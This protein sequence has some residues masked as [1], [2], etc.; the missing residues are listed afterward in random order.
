MLE[1]AMKK[2]GVTEPT[3]SV[4]I[5]TLNS[6][7]TLKVCLESIVSQSYPVDKLEIIVADAGSTDGT[8]KVIEEVASKSE[9]VIKVVANRLKT[10]EAGKAAGL[11]CAR[12]EVI[13]LIDSDNVLSGVDWLEKM[14][15]PFADGSVV[16]SEPI[17]YT[18]RKKD[19]FITRYCALIGMNDP[20]CLFLGN[21]DRYSTVTGLWTEM[22]HRSSDRGGYLVIELDKERLPTIGANGFLIYRSVLQGCDTGEYLFDIDVVHELLEG[23]KPSEPVH[24]AKVKTGIIHIFSGDVKTFARKQRRR[25]RD[26][27]YYNRLGVRKYPWKSHG[28][29]G[30]ARFIFSCVTVVPLLSQSL[31]GYMKRPDAAWLFHAAACWI[32]LYEYSRGT[33]SGIFGAAELT[34]EGWRQ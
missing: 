18:Y 8:L 11:K 5:P 31:K 14:V 30:L 33:V 16:A 28:R 4:V 9:F 7:K 17:E 6:G 27:Q 3:V 19:G 34:R 12:G 10:G 22:P 25:I 23:A 13:A 24:F 26:Y 29:R 15:E 2:G 1:G 21:Y 20:L 32:T